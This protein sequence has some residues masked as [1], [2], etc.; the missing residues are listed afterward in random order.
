MLTGAIK[1]LAGVGQ[2]VL[3][4]TL[5]PMIQG[6]FEQL[7]VIFTQRFNDRDLIIQ[8]NDLIQRAVKALG[9]QLVNPQFYS[10]LV[11]NLLQCFSQN[12]H[13]LSCL[14]T[15]SYLC[16]QVGKDPQ[17]KQITLQ[18]IDAICDHV[19]RLMANNQSNIDVDLI[20]DFS[21]VML[22]SAEVDISHS[23]LS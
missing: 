3:S 12:A 22:R 23:I 15:F 21:E 19:L 5:L 10:V 17:N 16:I 11:T 9:P 13:N 8:T 7:S 20:K 2:D 6:I 14:T 1:A 4:L 18:N